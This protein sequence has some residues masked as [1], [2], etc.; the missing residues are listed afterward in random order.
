M[1]S[2]GLHTFGVLT[3]IR[4]LSNVLKI[5]ENSNQVALR[6]I[7]SCLTPLIQVGTVPSEAL[8]QY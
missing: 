8:R 6:G 1:A 4:V 3:A 2:D 5:N 7:A